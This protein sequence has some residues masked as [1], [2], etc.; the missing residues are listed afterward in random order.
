M[1]SDL[2]DCECADWVKDHAFVV[3]L[4]KAETVDKLV[5]K[6]KAG[7]VIAKETV[8]ADRE[9]SCISTPPLS[10]SF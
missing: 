2:G 1:T 5:D 10:N 6:L 4:V 7:D 8:I 9:S 3:N